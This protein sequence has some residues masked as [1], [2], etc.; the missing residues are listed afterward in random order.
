[1]FR[2]TSLTE[3]PDAQLNRWIRRI[4]LLFFVVL[5]AFV[6]LYALDRFKA[7]AA[8]IAD[9]EI[10]QL[11]EAVRQDPSNVAVRGQLAD[12]Y[13]ARGRYGEAITLYTQIIDS[14]KELR[15]AY[16]GRGRAHQLNGDDDAAVADFGKVI[17]MSTGGEMAMIDGALARSY[18]SIGQIQLKQGR[19]LDAIDN[20]GKALRIKPT[21]ADTMN[22]LSQ[23]YLA[24]GNADKAIEQAEQAIR[25]V[26]VGWA[27]PY[28]TLA[29]AYTAKGE[30]EMGQWASAM[31]Q[32]QTGDTDGATAALA[33]LVDGKA[34]LEALIS[35]GLIAERSGDTAAAAD[36]YRKA[37]ERDTGNE[38]ATMG[39]SRVTSGTQSHPSVGPSVAPSPSAE[40]SN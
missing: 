5:V 6:A 3:M 30:T 4:G 11:E 33:R 1:M 32:A 26:P 9:R 22:L 18:F 28:Q 8:P 16:V 12:T 25:F 35:L 19:A 15:P 24:A 38:A 31:A 29:S 37:L 27:D 14:G 39:L 10:A 7:P 21:D 20:L 17:E 36:W 13:V 34:G 2:V 40:G 23:A